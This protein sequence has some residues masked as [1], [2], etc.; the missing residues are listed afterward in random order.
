V[1]L[2]VAMFGTSANVE[3][4]RHAAIAASLRFNRDS[5]SSN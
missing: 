1:S 2:D 3:R 5:A 4:K